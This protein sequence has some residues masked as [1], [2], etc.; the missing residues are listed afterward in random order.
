MENMHEALF[1]SRLHEIKT[2]GHISKFR[3]SKDG[4]EIPWNV[5]SIAKAIK[6]SMSPGDQKN[7][8]NLL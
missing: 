4:K 2:S 6:E 8:K 1:D 3:V 5:E 7:I